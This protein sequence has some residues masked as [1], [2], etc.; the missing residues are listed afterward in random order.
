MATGGSKAARDGQPGELWAFTTHRSMADIFAADPAWGTDSHDTEITAPK[1]HFVQAH[2]AAHL[3]VGIPCP[4]GC[5][6]Y[7]TLSNAQ[8]RP[9]Q[10]TGPRQ[11]AG[12][13]PRP[14]ATPL[15]PHNGDH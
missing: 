6:S 7:P 3:S 8:A 11:A 13:S 4:L 2:P 5:P 12:P 1:S 10:S 15:S 14:A 9:R